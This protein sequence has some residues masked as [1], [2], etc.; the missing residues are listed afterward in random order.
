[1]IANA[2]AIRAQ[3][4]GKRR[5]A[6]DRR[7]QLVE[8]GAGVVKRGAQARD[9]RHAAKRDITRV[10]RLCDARL[11]GVGKSAYARRRAEVIDAGSA[12]GAEVAVER[13]ELEAQA[14]EL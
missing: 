2:Y 7:A 8:H 10:T 12:S 9:A 4:R 11:P 1:M 5:E 6:I 14:V 13:I 3:L